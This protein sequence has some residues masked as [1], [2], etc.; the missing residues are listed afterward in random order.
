[1]IEIWCVK[2][3]ERLELVVEGQVT[4]E[5]KRY[6]APRKLQ[7]T[8]VTKQGN[9]RYY[10]LEEGD[11]VLF[12]WKGK[13]L[14]RGTVFS[15][16]PR[17]NTLF[18]EAYDMLTY[19]VR[20][21]DVYAF[22][23]QRADQIVRRIC[24]DFQIPTTTIVNTGVTFKSLLVT[25]ETTLY[26]IILKA[27]KRTRANNGRNYQLYSTKGKLGLRAWPDP[28]E[29]YVIEKGVN[30]ISYEYSTSIEET[31]TRV[32]MKMQKNDKTYTA[33]ARDNDGARKFGVLQYTET[34]TDDLNQAQLKRRADNKQKELKGVQRKLNGVQAIGIPDVTS[35]LPVRVIIKDVGINR[36]YWVDSDSHT[37]QGNT[38]KMTLD[39]VRNNRI[40]E[41]S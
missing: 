19:L 11:T 36:N 30:L 4:W 16:I 33:T 23:N 7:A 25:Q 18:F 29:V 2:P 13:E 1:M 38:H 39:L 40:P 14:F 24:N 9:Q 35:G 12:K 20:N 22:S 5:G 34:V 21:K 17:D 26:D 27:L 3:T 32:K 6:Q 28:S 10:T 15:R 37:F 8:I 41:V 31:A